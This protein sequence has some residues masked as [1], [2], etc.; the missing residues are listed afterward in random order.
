VR[1]RPAPQTGLTL[2]AGGGFIDIGRAVSVSCGNTSCNGSDVNPSYSVGVLFWIT[3]HIGAEASFTKPGNVT[4]HGNGD[5]FRFNSTFDADVVT[6]GGNAGFP[7]GSTR[8]YG[9]GGLDH[10]R[11]TLTTS[12]TTNDTTVTV[13]G[14][15]QTIPGGTQQFELKTDGW[16]WFVGGGVEVWLTRALA[17]YA[18][19][20]R[21][22]L[23]GDA[24]G[25]VEGSLD[26]HMTYMLAGARVRI[27][28]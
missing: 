15:T 9:H 23:K 20:G 10:H 18:E 6:I 21:A 26:D 13:D 19:L 12:E 1:I 3:P 14:V 2:F 5:T 28:R 25:G 17:F 4:T 24:L 16:S 11:A 27:G 22:Q 8:I 7:V